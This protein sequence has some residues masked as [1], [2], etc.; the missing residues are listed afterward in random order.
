MAG[1]V[2]EIGSEGTVKAMHSDAF[3]LGFLGRKEVRRQTEIKFNADSQ[4]WDIHYLKEDGTEVRHE[5]LDEFGGYEE[6]RQFEV[7][8]VNLCRFHDIEPEGEEG[9]KYMG[10]LRWADTRQCF[11]LSNGGCASTGGKHAIAVL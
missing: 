2:I 10:W 4:K 7:L 1:L 6:A 9:L 5:N 8:W 11:P 3:D